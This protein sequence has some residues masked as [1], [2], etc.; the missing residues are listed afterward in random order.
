MKK[1]DKDIELL[2]YKIQQMQSG[3]G[4]G[5]AGVKSGVETHLVAN[6]KKGNRELRNELNNARAEVE[7]I[8]KDIKRTRFAE[9]EVEL[10]QYIEE[11]NRLRLM[12]EN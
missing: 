11:C 10:A 6:L 8:K 2:A 12:L 3:F 4:G 1:K 7:K 5:G 9:L